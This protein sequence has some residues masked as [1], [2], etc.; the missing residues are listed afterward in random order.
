MKM[1]KHFL[2]LLTLVFASAFTH[3]AWNPKWISVNIPEK[4]VAIG[5]GN[6]T[7]VEVEFQNAKPGPHTEV[8]ISVRDTDI[9]KTVKVGNLSEPKFSTGIDIS[10]SPLGLYIFD[11]A[12]GNALLRT[13]VAHRSVIVQAIRNLSMEINEKNP[14]SGKDLEV[15]PNTE[16]QF[17]PIPQFRFFASLKSSFLKFW[18]IFEI[19]PVVD[20]T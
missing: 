10:R 5:S 7:T 13:D 20:N 18:F 17:S 12:I 8:K 1:K 4:V 9:S 19:F 14:T 11:V 3:A 6:E 15:L 2:Y 16:V